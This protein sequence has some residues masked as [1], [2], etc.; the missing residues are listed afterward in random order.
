MA[1]RPASLTEWSDTFLGCRIWIEPRSVRHAIYYRRRLLFCVSPC[2]LV[3][4]K[5]LSGRIGCC[6][7]HWFDQ[8][9]G[10]SR[11]LCRTANNGLPGYAYPFL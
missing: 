1:R 5:R 6:S 9:G 2:I 11:R 4:S 7:I 8:L 10:K 3:S